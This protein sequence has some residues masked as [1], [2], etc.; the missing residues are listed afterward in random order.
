MVMPNSV[1]T[2][3]LLWRSSGDASANLYALNELSLV[4]E[5]SVGLSHSGLVGRN[6]RHQ[7]SYE[8]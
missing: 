3:G 1:D 8:E 2:A 7:A 5:I 6:N 4:V